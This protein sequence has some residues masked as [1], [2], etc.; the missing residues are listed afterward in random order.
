[1]MTTTSN[2]RKER[3]IDGLCDAILN[4]I[5]SNAWQTRTCVLC[6]KRVPDGPMFYGGT[7]MECFYNEENEKS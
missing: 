5:M 6:G 3:T 4:R 1:M 2:V 7:C